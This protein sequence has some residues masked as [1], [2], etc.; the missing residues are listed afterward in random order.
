MTKVNKTTTAYLLTYG[1][2]CLDCS[3]QW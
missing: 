3:E 1:L 2:R